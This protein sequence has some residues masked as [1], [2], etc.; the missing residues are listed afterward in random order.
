MIIAV[1]FTLAGGDVDFYDDEILETPVRYRQDIQ[2]QEN[3]STPPFQFEEGDEWIVLEINFI[4]SQKDTNTRI[5]QLI[6]EQ[7]EMACYYKYK[8]DASTSINV[9][10]YPNE[11]TKIY[12]YVVGESEAYVTHKLTFLQSS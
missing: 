10:Y 11:K 4:E 12:N 7:A 6:D 3:Q 5:N 1:K 2:I 9:I 8:Y